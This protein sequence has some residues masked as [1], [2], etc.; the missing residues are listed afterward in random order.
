ML[1]LFASNSLLYPQLLEHGRYSVFMYWM[2]KMNEGILT[3][4]LYKADM[5]L[6]LVID[7]TKS[8]IQSLCFHLIVIWPP[9]QKLRHRAVK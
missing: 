5:F 3:I 8:L 1:L 9:Q 7:K 4:T 2:N 6:Q